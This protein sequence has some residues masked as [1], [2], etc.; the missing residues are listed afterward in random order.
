MSTYDSIY[1]PTTYSLNLSDAAA[2]RIAS[3]L[4]ADD[5]LAMKDWL[6]A[7]GIAEDEIDI[8]DTTSLVGLW[9]SNYDPAKGLSGM[10]IAKQRYYQEARC[11]SQRDT[12][13]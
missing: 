6:V 7:D 5:R 11:L 9:D 10:T 4:S 13:H 2:K 1:S 3:K 12:V 8:A